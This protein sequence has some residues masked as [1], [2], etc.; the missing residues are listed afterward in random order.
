MCVLAGMYV[1]LCTYIRVQIHL[2]R[3]EE[4]Y[5]LIA[6]LNGNPMYAVSDSSSQLFG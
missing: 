5:L 1:P 3:G 6:I 4:G 2:E